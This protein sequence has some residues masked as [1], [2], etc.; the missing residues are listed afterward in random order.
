MVTSLSSDL[1]NLL[2]EVPE[3]E[4]SK[5]QY[6]QIFELRDDAG[7]YFVNEPT[8]KQ[9]ELLR[10]FRLQIHEIREERIIEFHLNDEHSSL[11]GKYIQIEDPSSL[12]LLNWIERHGIT[13]YEIRVEESDQIG[14][15]DEQEFI[16]EFVMAID[17]SANLSIRG[18]N[19]CLKIAA[20]KVGITFERA[21]K[22]Y[23]RRF[24]TATL[25][26]LIEQ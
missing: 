5:N 8:S 11:L 14:K 15:I 16:D 4:G 12:Q 13:Y 3:I 2:T 1:N 6:V 26:S 24:N 18:I 9:N 22:I 7:L 19:N 10:L 20:S 21:E 17:S 25:K 23:L